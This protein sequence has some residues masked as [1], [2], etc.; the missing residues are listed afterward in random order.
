LLQ[1]S[2]TS[3]FIKQ[4]RLCVD[5]IERSELCRSVPVDVESIPPKLLI[6]E[7]EHIATIFNVSDRPGNDACCVDYMCD[8]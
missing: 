4:S 8:F 2:D 5:V 3:C 1:V 6:A 7:V